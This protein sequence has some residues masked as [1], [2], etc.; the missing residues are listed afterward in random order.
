MLNSL[1]KLRSHLLAIEELFFRWL[2]RAVVAGLLIGSAWLDD[3]PPLDIAAMLVS[4]YVLLRLLLEAGQFYEAAPFPSRILN[5]LT[6]LFALLVLGLCFLSV[7]V[8]TDYIAVS[9]AP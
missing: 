6:A 1:T 9:V 7:A 3:A 4:L 5:G 2:F 8:F